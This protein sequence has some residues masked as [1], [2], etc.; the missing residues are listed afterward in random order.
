MVADD[1]AVVVT[2]AKAKTFPVVPVPNIKKLSPNGFVE[3]R[4]P[5]PE[6]VEFVDAFRVTKP[7]SVDGAVMPVRLDPKN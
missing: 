7:V 1:S 2:I 3:G 5:L 6:R 4:L